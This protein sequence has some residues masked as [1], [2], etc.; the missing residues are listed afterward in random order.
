MLDGLIGNVP[1]TDKKTLRH[2]AVILPHVEILKVSKRQQHCLKRRGVN[3]DA[4]NVVN[5]AVRS[6]ITPATKGRDKGTYVDER[7]SGGVLLTHD[8]MLASL[9]EKKD[10]KVNKQQA[11]LKRAEKRCRAKLDKANTKM[12]LAAKKALDREE[13]IREKVKATEEKEL[14]TAELHRLKERKA[15]AS[16][17]RNREKRELQ[18]MR[19]HDKTLTKKRRMSVVAWVDL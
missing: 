1:S 8:E 14:K 12:K 3:M 16:A 15:H 4:L 19:Q 9:E 10:T 7:F 6:S 18:L 2:H 5:I 11:K 13:R 17:E